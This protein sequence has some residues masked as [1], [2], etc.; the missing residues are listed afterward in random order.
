MTPSLLLRYIPQLYFIQPFNFIF[1]FFTLENLIPLVDVVFI[2]KDFAQHNGLESKEETFEK[3]IKLCKE[4]SILICPWGEDGAIAGTTDG[5][6]HTSNIF[7]P[8]MV[9]DTLGAGMPNFT[10]VK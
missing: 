2:S 8:E 10:T 6:T 5:R 1:F 4:N 9:L 7:P 3:Y